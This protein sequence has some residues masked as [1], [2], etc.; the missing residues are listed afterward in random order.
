MITVRWHNYWM[1]KANTIARRMWHSWTRRYY[2]TLQVDC[3]NRRDPKHWME[4]GDK[5]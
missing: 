3:R 2:K 5:Y 1:L 4:M